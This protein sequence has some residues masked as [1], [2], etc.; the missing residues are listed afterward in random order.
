MT[1]ASELPHAVEHLFTQTAPQ[2]SN[3]YTTDFLL[4]DYLSAHIPSAQLTEYELGLSHMGKLAAGELY[5]LQLA[6]LPNL[7]RL[8]SWDA[9]G[10]RID[11]IELTA[12]WQRAAPLAA[13]HGLIAHGYDRTQGASA[14]LHQFAMAYLFIPSTDFFGC[15]LARPTVPPQP[16]W[17]R[18]TKR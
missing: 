13:E 7:P 1:R 10:R 14:R 11:H 8:S 2:L 18:G 6:D 4:R 16:Y 5:H 15:P 17:H 12:M 9:W 3:S